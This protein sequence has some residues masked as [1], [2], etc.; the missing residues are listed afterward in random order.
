MPAPRKSLHPH[1]SRALP[2]IGS[3]LRDARLARHLSLEEVGQR[4]GR[5]RQLIAKAEKHP[6]QVAAEVLMDIVAVYDPLWP[7]R[8][9]AAFEQDPIGD[10]L[11][12]QSQPTRGRSAQEDF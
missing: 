12:R 11:R 6:G 2:A 10:I 9:V 8:I 5:T 4:C 3:A 7:G 1:A